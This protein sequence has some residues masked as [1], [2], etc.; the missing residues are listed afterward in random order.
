MRF[1][2]IKRLL[3]LPLVFLASS[4]IA[5]PP[6]AIP[7]TAVAKD[8]YGNPAKN[9]TVYVKDI[10]FQGQAVGGTKMWEETFVVTTNEDGIY[11]I[12]IGKGTKLPAIPI[13]DLT[14]ID[15]GN[16]PYFLNLKVAVAPSIPASWW[17]ANDNYLDMGTSQMMSVAYA[18]FAGNASV[19]NVST[20]LPPGLPDR[21]SV[22]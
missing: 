1:L 10:I 19:T 11:T 20:S 22:V 21:K 15:W 16:G 17:V 5:Q 3:I 13:A 14:G 12:I 4:A 6:P 18:M 9:R 2:T 7:I 8:P